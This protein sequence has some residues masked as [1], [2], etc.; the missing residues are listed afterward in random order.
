MLGAPPEACVVFEDAPAGV[1][2]ALAAGMRVVALPAPDHVSMI[3][4]AH[5]I[6]SGLAAFEPETW[7]LPG[8]G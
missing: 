6:L 4:R 5:A 2:A 8:Y 1:Q 7:G 3:E